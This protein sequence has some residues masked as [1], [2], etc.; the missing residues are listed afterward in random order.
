MTRSLLSADIKVL[1][2]WI[3]IMRTPKPRQ[4]REAFS[5]VTIKVLLEVLVPLA[6]IYIAHPS[7]LVDSLPLGWNPAPRYAA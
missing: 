5:R 7:F 1:R 6:A 4:A 3:S 2:C